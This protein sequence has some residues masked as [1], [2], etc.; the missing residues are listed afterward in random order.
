MSELFGFMGTARSTTA[1]DGALT[2][3]VAAGTRVKLALSP[4]AQGLYLADVLQNGLS[5][6]DSGFDARADAAPVQVVLNT[7]G[8][9]VRGSI[10][11]SA[12]RSL[13]NSIVALV[14]AEDRR[15]N[16]ALYRSAV[17]DATGRFTLVSI[18]AGQY[19]LFAWGSGL[20]T[21]SFYNP[22]FLARYEDRG[23]AINVAPAA[24]M[25]AEPLRMPLD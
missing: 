24:I 10:Q 25:D 19:K 8:G 9:T 17:T 5:V 7:D 16:R 20:P 21:G 23:R 15:Q 18:V 12:G 11:D 22:A 3:S 6:F 14:P 2:I 13:P 4:L 1:P